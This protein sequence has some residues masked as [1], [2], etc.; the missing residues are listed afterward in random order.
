MELSKELLAMI[1]SEVPPW[2]LY[3]RCR[4]VHP[5]W[6]ALIDGHIYKRRGNLCW[7]RRIKFEPEIRRMSAVLCEL[8]A[9]PQIRIAPERDK[10]IACPETDVNIRLEV[11]KIWG[12]RNLK[13]DLI[14]FLSTALD[15]EHIIAFY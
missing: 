1:L 10:L 11:I 4:E 6:K 5:L 13:E 2:D 9:K 8:V 12:L 7:A 14:L 3:F 15:K